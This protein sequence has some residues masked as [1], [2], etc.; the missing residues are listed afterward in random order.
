MQLGGR[1]HLQGGVDAG[2]HALQRRLQVLVPRLDAARAEHAA[3]EGVLQTEHVK[4]SQGRQRGC[5]YLN[6]A[7]AAATSAAAYYCGRTVLKYAEI[8]YCFFCSPLTSLRETKMQ[9]AA[10]AGKSCIGP[11]PVP[12]VEVGKQ[13]GWTAAP[14]ASSNRHQFEK[15]CCAAALQKKHGQ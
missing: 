12:A 7:V 3:A 5:P 6:A 14:I 4:E 8:L 11:L 2:A 1:W 9:P 13:V 15:H 10:N